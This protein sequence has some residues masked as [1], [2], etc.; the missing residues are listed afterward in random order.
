MKLSD[1]RGTGI[2]AG[3]SGGFM[4]HFGLYG[5]GNILN[6]KIGSKGGTL[7]IGVG[8]GGAASNMVGTSWVCGTDRCGGGTRPPSN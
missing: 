3:Y 2:Q 4:G 5:V 1:L 8:G 6:G 7:T